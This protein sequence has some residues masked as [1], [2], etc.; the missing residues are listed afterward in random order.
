[1]NDL[2]NSINSKLQEQKR[3]EYQALVQKEI[4]SNFPDPEARAIIVKQMVLLVEPHL[5]KE[6]QDQ[7]H[8]LYLEH[9]KYNQPIPKNLA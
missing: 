5:T 8:F 9:Q 3:R 6:V 2:T 4:N 7:L 1:M